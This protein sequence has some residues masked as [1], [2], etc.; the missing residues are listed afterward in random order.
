MNIDELVSRGGIVYSQM[1]A[2]TALASKKMG[3]RP[4]ISIYLR[5]LMTYIDR[6]ET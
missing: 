3:L 2:L 5:N 4:K 6:I 1:E